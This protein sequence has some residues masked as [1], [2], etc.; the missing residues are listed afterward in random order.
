MGNI[1]LYALLYYLVIHFLLQPGE[2]GVSFERHVKLLQAEFLK[3]KRNP[4][5]TSELMFKTFPLRRVECLEQ[6]H[7]LPKFGFPFIQEIDHVSALG[8]VKIKGILSDP[9]SCPLVYIVYKN[10]LLPSLIALCC[11]NTL[12]CYS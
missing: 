5:I 4:Q 3:A 12:Y 7:S 9:T 10:S 6:S 1:V 11:V 2:D 8:G